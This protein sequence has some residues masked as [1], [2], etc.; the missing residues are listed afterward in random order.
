[1]TPGNSQVPPTT[2]R[3]SLGVLLAFA[4]TALWSL[5]FITS[6]YA[7]FAYN[8]ET[9]STLWF[10][11]A[12]IYGYIYLKLA[13]RTDIWGH[14]RQVWRPILAVGLLNGL[15]SLAGFGSL[16]L[17]DP[18]LA[19]FFGRTQIIFSVLLG[20]IVLRERLSLTEGL[21]AILAVTGLFI[22]SYKGGTV[23][24]LGL[25]L[26]LLG[27][28]GASLQ[29]FIVKVSV[30]EVD[31]LVMV[32]FRTALAAVTVATVAFS[33]GRFE[34]VHA[35]LNLTVLLVGAFFGPFLAHVCLFRG[36]AHIDLTKATIIQTTNPLFVILY[37]V[38]L[39][40]LLPG[41]PEG[42]QLFPTPVQLAGGAVLLIGVATLV[43]GGRAKAN[44]ARKQAATEEC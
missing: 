11:A 16:R 22:C 8:L 31:P 44:S 20:W 35:P 37:A 9:F 24:L 2:P 4:Y 19:A 5:N 41:I 1:M 10:V 21:G 32:F 40:P 17:I 38:A 18:S 33:T 34:L 39:L 3:A 27:A 28:I 43:M 29:Y 23:V 14:M 36:L 26:S 12:S 42:V 6:K 15:A 7:M 25:V 30:K 13:G